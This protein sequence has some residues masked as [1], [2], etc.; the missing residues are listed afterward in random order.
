MKNKRVRHERIVELKHKLREYFIFP[1]N[2]RR[3][4]GLV[5]MRFLL[6]VL[7]LEHHLGYELPNIRQRFY[8]PKYRK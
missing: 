6:D 3:D 4:D 1:C 2:L 5:E 8:D 7:E